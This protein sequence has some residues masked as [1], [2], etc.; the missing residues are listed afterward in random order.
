MLPARFGFRSPSR[1][2]GAVAQI[3]AIRSP[4]GVIARAGNGLQPRSIKDCDDSARI[5]NESLIL[6]LAGDVRDAT[7][8]HTQHVR[9]ELVGEAERVAARAIMR[10]EQP[11]R[12]TCPEKVGAIAGRR[13]RE[14]R[15]KHEKIP[16]EGAAK[17]TAF[18]HYLGKAA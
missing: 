3:F 8:S 18:L 17:R 16:V 14:L 13:L 5:A 6:Q 12:G 7:A 9:Q 4:D 11:S 10:H 2:A 1:L 15:R